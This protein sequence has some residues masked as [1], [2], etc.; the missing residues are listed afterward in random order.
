MPV[1]TY[2]MSSR[3]TNHDRMAS[4]TIDIIPLDYVYLYILRPA[5]YLLIIDYIIYIV[6]TQ[7]IRI[8]TFLQCTITY[9]Y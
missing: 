8:V 5:Y 1:G 4:L 2:I 7:I 6:I 3:V 9:V